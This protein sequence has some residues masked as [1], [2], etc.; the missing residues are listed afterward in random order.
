MLARVL[1]AGAAPGPR[2]R[3]VLL[4]GGPVAAALLERAVDAGFPISQTYG[5]TE[6]CSMVTRG[7]ARRP[8]DRGPRAARH[9]R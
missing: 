8:R 4:G 1:D 6:A 7:R 5:L 2:L 3:R 9:R